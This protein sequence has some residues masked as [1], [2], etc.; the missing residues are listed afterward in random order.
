MLN[1]M[2]NAF[3]LHAQLAKDTIVLLDWPLCKVLLMNDSQYPWLI[4]V[5]RRL[6]IKEIYQLEFTD[7]QQLLQEINAAS[8][9]LLNCQPDKLNVAALGNQVAQLHVHVIARFKSDLAWPK[10]VWGAT[11]AKPYAVTQLDKIVGQYQQWLT[12]FHAMV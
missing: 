8:Q 9:A 6:A 4:L 2:V 5:P 7:Q 3:T 10:L 1:N 11:P 12:K